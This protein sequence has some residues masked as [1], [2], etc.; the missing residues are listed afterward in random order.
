MLGMGDGIK[1]LLQMIKSLYL[2]GGICETYRNDYVVNSKRA[3]HYQVL[4]N[5]CRREYDI[6][7]KNPGCYI[8]K[9]S[10]CRSLLVETYEV[11][12]GE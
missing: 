6:E 9:I 10:G 11:W 1:E 8:V 12:G 2:F 7:E 5:T 3:W 4:V